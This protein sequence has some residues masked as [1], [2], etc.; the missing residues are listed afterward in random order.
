[1][2]QFVRPDWPASARVCA[3][4][5]TRHG[6]VSKPPYDAFNLAMQ[7]GEAAEITMENRRILR[8]RLRLPSEPLWCRQVH[9]CQTIVAEPGLIAGAPPQADASVCFD[10]HSVCVVTTADC[11][12]VFF[13]DREETRVGVA[14][15][16]WRGLAQGVLMETVK[17][18]RT[19]PANL[20]AWLGPAI[21]PQAYQVG[22]EV[23][24]VF[25]EQSTAYASAFLP[26]NTGRWTANLYALA[27]RQLKRMGIGWLGGYLTCTYYSRQ[28]YSFRHNPTTGRM[29][30]LIWLSKPNGSCPRA[31]AA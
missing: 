10:A 16:G 17:A 4:T 5:T 13:C 6:G 25:I 7:P 24:D 14:H 1:M 9:G 26:D 31:A 3:C 12:P 28:F 11:L 29:A 30:N 2:N 20:M 22:D 21:G 18:L 23:R 19:Q 27:H 8:A 15:A